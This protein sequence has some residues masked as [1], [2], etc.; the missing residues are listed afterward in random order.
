MFR[1]AYRNFGSHESLVVNHTV[2]VTTPPGSTVTQANHQAG[3]RFTSSS[4]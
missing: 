1:L 2:N 3:V 4:G